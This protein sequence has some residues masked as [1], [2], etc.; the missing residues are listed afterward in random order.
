MPRGR[1]KKEEG[2]VYQ[3]QL[4]D[5]GKQK[6]GKEKGIVV[7]GSELKKNNYFK[8]MQFD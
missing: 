4:P 2:L 8:G 6:I 7:Y 3:G 1:C 5:I